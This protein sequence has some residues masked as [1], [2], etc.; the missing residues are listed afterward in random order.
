MLLGDGAIVINMLIQLWEQEPQACRKWLEKLTDAVLVEL[1]PSP[2]AALIES[3]ASN[4]TELQERSVFTHIF[5]AMSHSEHPEKLQPLA[6]QTAR[7]LLGNEDKVWQEAKEFLG[8]LSGRAPQAMDWMKICTV[9]VMNGLTGGSLDAI[10]R[11]LTSELVRLGI[12]PNEKAESSQS[13]AL[14]KA[15]ISKATWHRWINKEKIPDV[16]RRDV[17]GWRLFTEE[18]IQRIREFANLVNLS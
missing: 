11:D 15:G 1:L 4:V 6:S 14:K 17:R 3:V 12:T 9:N 10:P 13:E 7:L 18:D 2:P 8:W 16:K 5:I